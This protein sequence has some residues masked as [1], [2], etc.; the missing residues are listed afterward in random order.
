[1]DFDEISD[2]IARVDCKK[3]ESWNPL[4]REKIF[5][6][7]RKTVGFDTVNGMVF[8]QLRLWVIAAATQAIAIETNEQA[9]YQLK[10]SLARL[11][12]GQSKYT[13]AETLFNE[14]LT[15]KISVT[16]VEGAADITSY[17]GENQT[18]QCKNCVLLHVV[19][20]IQIS[21][22]PII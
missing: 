3:S 16:D 22:I 21:V 4:D 7:V 20:V 8:E 17:I 15:Y 9:R 14:I 11:Y 2:M 19:I 6:V 5:D 12:M 10:L 1:M 18:Q 13:Q